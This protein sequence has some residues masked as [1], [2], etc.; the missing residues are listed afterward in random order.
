MPTLATDRVHVLVSSRPNPELPEDVPVGHPLRAIAAA[1]GAVKVQP[2]KDAE[3]LAALARQEITDLV[4]RPDHL[5]AHV[6]GLLT[7]AA[8]PLSVRD[9]ATLSGNLADP[10]NG[11]AEPSVD[12]VFDIN[13][14]LTEDAARSLQPVGVDEDQRYQFAHGSLLEYAET[15]RYLAHRRFRDSIHQWADR[16]RDAG[17]P[18]MPDSEATTPRYLLDTYPSTLANDPRRLAALVGIGW[19]A[20]AIQAAGVDAILA[21]IRTAQGVVADAQIS[22]MLAIVQGQALNL[23]PP[24]PVTQPGY[25]LRQLCLQ[26]CELTEDRLAASARGQLE[27]LVNPGPV[28]LW[29]TRRA[30]H[31]L[32]AEFGGDDDSVQAMAALVDGR[33]IIGGD[34]GRMLLWDP[35]TLGATPLEFG[36]HDDAAG[37]VA[38][39][40]D[41]R[42]VRG[43]WDGRLRIWDPDTPGAAP[44]ELAD[45]G[46]DDDL[47][48]QT[49][50][51]A[52]AVLPDGRVVSG[53]ADGQVRVWDPAT[54][55]VAPLEL[56]GDAR[57]LL[58][59]TLGP[60][61]D[62][63]DD[64]YNAMT[65]LALAVL[66]DGRVVSGRRG[67]GDGRL[68]VWDPATPGA[69]PIEL[70]ADDY[71]SAVAVAALPDG[72]VVCSRILADYS[73]ASPS[74]KIENS[75]LQVWDPAAPEAAPIERGCND[76][77]TTVAALPDGRVVS[78]G[79][80]GR[81]WV[82]DPATPEAAQLELGS[83]DGWVQ[84][85]AVLPDGRVVSGGDDG[86]VRVWDPATPEAAQFRL[87]GDDDDDSLVA[88]QAVAVLPDGR[89]V[90]G[91]DDGRVRVW[92]PDTPGAAPLGLGDHDN[93]L[94]GRV[95]DK[96]AGGANGRAGGQWREGLAALAGTGV[97]SGH[98]WGR[99]GSSS[100]AP[101]VWCGLWRCFRT[102]GW[103]AAGSTGRF[104]SGTRPPPGPR[105]SGSPTTTTSSC[106]G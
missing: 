59:A 48:E 106:R 55:R 13:R 65:V 29:T 85:V 81:V 69:G 23:R 39:L 71:S 60:V 12:D 89:V 7:A 1:R 47:D 53:G 37:A 87:S 49:W 72:R 97:G 20:A 50:V 31:A 94:P 19:A 6:L 9:L 57:G 11:L 2:F 90:S 88:V 25:V 101:A 66:P 95:R 102:T 22:A 76:R 74:L 105:R 4:R 84:A 62:D 34:G 44:L 33:V 92:D 28:P 26:A 78:G 63:D 16:W 52:V 58:A 42:V 36:S 24:Q 99:A 10:S 73:I 38:V 18:T 45:H 77:V 70:G 8:G 32:T 64:D 75:R 98:P 104:G 93:L 17:W 96:C 103:S 40:P 5:A 79:W 43:G 51:G 27:A 41:G 3:K 100:A 30:S 82:W 80:D 21:T 35:V 68:Q 56:G 83:H 54:P 46:P 67:F 91:G 86:R 14:F 61:D 15:D